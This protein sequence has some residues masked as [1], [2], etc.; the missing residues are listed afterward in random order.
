MFWQYKLGYIYDNGLGV[1]KDSK[2]AYEYYLSAGKKAMLMHN[3][4]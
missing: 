3:I 1:Q 2:K 4:I